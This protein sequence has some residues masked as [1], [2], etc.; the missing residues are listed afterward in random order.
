MDSRGFEDVALTG[1]YN[2]IWMKEEERVLRM[3]LR[4]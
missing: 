4:F 3:I 2:Q 1:S